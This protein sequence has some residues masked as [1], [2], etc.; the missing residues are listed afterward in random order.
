MTG[1]FLMWNSTLQAQLRVHHIFDNNMVLQRD[2]PVRVWGWANVGKEVTVEFAGQKKN[3][4]VQPDGQWEVILDPMAVSRIPGLFK[5]TSEGEAV[6]YQ[7]VLVGDVWILGGQSNMEFDLK[8]IY[9]GDEEVASAHFPEIRLMTIPAKARP[10]LLDDFPRLNEWNG[11][12]GRYDL[13]GY[14]MVCSPETVPTFS[15]LGYIFGRRVYMATQ[16]PIGLIDASW[17]GTTVEA[18]VSRDQLKTIDRNRGLL[19]LWDARI[20]ADT[21]KA[22]DRNNPGASYNGMLGIFGG[23]SVKGILFHQGFNNALGDARP[24]LYGQNLEL[25]IRQWRAT[26]N[27]ASLPFG[28]IELSAGGEPQTL[29]NFEIRMVDAGCYIRE[30]Q[31]KAYLDLPDV[32]FVSA[33]DQ[34]VHWYHPFKKVELGERMA[35]WALATQYG[36][37]FGWKP[38][39]PNR[40]T[41]KD[42]QMIIGFDR[43]VVTHDGRPVEGMAIAGA[44]R[45]FYPAKAEYLVVGKDDRGRDQ[46][47]QSQL[48]VHCKQVSKPVAVRYAWARNPLGNLVNG[49]HLEQVI[50]VP[51]FR[52]DQWDWPEAPFAENKAPVFQAHRQKIRDLKQQA[53]QWA[54]RR[55]KP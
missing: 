9:H 14:W 25:M 12:Y 10:V 3:T 43:K 27:N 4:V 39:L 18:W 48:V 51:P 21:A 17:G 50:P 16:I 36:Y 34:Q 5:V 40:V 2:Q 38:A 35:R 52:T 13:K 28:I 30:A 29:D 11:W 1:V 41:S 8:R 33:Y 32:G 44:D 45:H 55:R 31:L 20:R 54:K 49:E 7:N 26:F 6:I 24:K 42:H 15:A 19:D 37:D 46:S 53:T 23:L 22:S 47:D